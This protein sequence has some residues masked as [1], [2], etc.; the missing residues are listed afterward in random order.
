MNFLLSTVVAF[1]I[2]TLLPTSSHAA[3]SISS[4]DAYMAVISGVAILVDVREETEISA[5][6]MAEPGLWLATSEIDAR[7][8]KY[9][10]A[11]QSWDRA[12]D[13]I[14]YCRSGSRAGKAADHFSSVGFRTF[15]AGSFQAWKDAGLPVK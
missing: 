4:R 8:E 12:K 6:G 9:E 2:S 11:V 1:F 15:N 5:T 3:S 13:I 10:Q 14:F 7:G